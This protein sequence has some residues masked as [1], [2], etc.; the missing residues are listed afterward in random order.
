MVGGEKLS[1]FMRKILTPGVEYCI[2]CRLEVNYSSRGEVAL[3]DH[4]R[5]A[6]HKALE[7]VP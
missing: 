1:L 2:V 7:T 3:E 6:K 4:V 5:T